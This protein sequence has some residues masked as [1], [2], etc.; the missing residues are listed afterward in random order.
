[1]AEQLIQCPKDPQIEYRREICETIFRK[2]NSRAWCRECK[3]F[4]PL[5]EASETA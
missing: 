1:M 5:E 4:E 3:N 2:Y